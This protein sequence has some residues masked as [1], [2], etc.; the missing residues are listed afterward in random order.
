[1][2]AHMLLAFCC[3]RF[4]HPGAYQIHFPAEAAV[5]SDKLRHEP[6]DRGTVERRQHAAPKCLRFSL[7][8]AADCTVLAGSR[9]VIAS[10]QTGSLMIVHLPREARYVLE[11]EPRDCGHFEAETAGDGGSFWHGQEQ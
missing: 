7:I 6:A 8:H 4:A 3:R 9:A 10:L 2:V 11:R 1:M 5:T